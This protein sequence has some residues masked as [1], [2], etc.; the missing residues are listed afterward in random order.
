M[1]HMRNVCYRNVFGYFI[2]KSLKALK[3]K[4]SMDKKQDARN[5]F[6]CCH[7]FDINNFRQKLKMCVGAIYKVSQVGEFWLNQAFGGN[8]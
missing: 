3:D 1:R 7:Y 4:K 2:R 6:I 5:F 8:F